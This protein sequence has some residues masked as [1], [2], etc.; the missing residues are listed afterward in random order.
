MKDITLLLNAADGYIQTV[1]VNCEKVI[2]FKEFEAPTKGTELLAPSLAQSF[3]ELGIVQTDI[4]KIAAVRGPGSFTGL[5]LVLTTASAY[6]RSF[7]LKQAGINYM[8]LLI[9]SL[10]LEDFKGQKELCVLLFARRDLCYMQEFSLGNGS[11]AVKSEPVLVSIDAIISAKIKYDIVIGNAISK[12][13]ELTKHFSDCEIYADIRPDASSYERILK[14]LAWQDNDIE[15]LY[16][17]Q[18]E[19]EDNLENLA[20][21]RG[22]DPTLARQSL[23]KLLTVKPNSII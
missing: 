15:P 16:L 21:R 17:K 9:N 22:D 13:D 8:E 5:R 2:L 12:S 3:Q 1:F 4:A 14:S 7:G 10:K 11:L 6:A 18:S 20:I 23:N 19:A